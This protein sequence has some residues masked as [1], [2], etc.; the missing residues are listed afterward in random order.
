MALAVS[1]SAGICLICA[2]FLAGCGVKPKLKDLEAPKKREQAVLQETVEVGTLD[3]KPDSEVPVSRSK[4][5]RG[6]ILDFLL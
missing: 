6:F 1:K 2:V 3:G 4:E 5:K